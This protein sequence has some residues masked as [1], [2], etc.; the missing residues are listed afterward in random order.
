MGFLNH[1]DLYGPFWLT[2]AVYT[3]N[4]YPQVGWI[5]S[6]YQIINEMDQAVNISSF[7][8]ESRHLNRREA[9]LEIIKSGLGL[10]YIARKEILSDV[11]SR[12]KALDEIFYP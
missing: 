11:E 5:A 8:N 3:F 10:G 9:F 4:K 1:D 12:C 6:A 7:I 2:F